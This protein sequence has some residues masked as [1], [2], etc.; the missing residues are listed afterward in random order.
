MKDVLNADPSVEAATPTVDVVITE[1]A[2]ASSTA[3][4]D[5]SSVVDS[6]LVV[7]PVAAAVPVVAKTRLFW[8]KSCD[9]VKESTMTEIKTG[10]NFTRTAHKVNV[11]H[12]GA[13]ESVENLVYSLKRGKRI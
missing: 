2:P 8:Q 1:N 10:E 4:A 11:L 6:N 5:G 12:V 9:S 13:T 7:V 3:L